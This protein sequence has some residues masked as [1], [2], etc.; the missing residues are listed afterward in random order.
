[1]TL[2]TYY[3]FIAGM[4]FA[5]PAKTVL[6]KSKG[7]TEP[8]YFVSY[9]NLNILDT[10]V[11]KKECIAKTYIDRGNDLHGKKGTYGKGQF[12]PGVITCQLTNGLP[13]TFH[14]ANGDEVS[15]C[16]FKDHSAIFAFDL[17]KVTKP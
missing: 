2:I 1:M 8:V 12:H 5:T 10:P 7:T 6:Y 15:I 17:I 16:E 13:L 11:C 4:S 14:Y 9:S 3:L